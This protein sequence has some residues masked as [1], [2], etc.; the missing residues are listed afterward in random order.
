MDDL[1]TC[2]LLCPDDRRTK[3]PFPSAF[4]FMNTF[5]CSQ[6]AAINHYG[7]HNKTAAESNK[8]REVWGTSFQLQFANNS[9]CA[10]CLNLH[11][12]IRLL[13]MHGYHPFTLGNAS[14]GVLYS[15]CTPQVTMLVPPKSSLPDD[16]RTPQPS[17]YA[18]T[19][20]LS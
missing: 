6:C 9:K 12:P 8:V 1:L 16:L 2:V 14:T 10:V 13:S 5:V 15:E 4:L 17:L 3:A 7:L 19:W 11:S 20:A 18:V